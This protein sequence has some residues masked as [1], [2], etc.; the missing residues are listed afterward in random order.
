MSSHNRRLNE[1]EAELDQNRQRMGGTLDALQKRLSTDDLFERVFG[2]L[3]TSGA[4][5][6]TH[7][8]SQSIRRNPVPLA[9][10]GIGLAW[11]AVAGS[12]RASRAVSE[13][14][15]SVNTERLGQAWSSAG[16]RTRSAADRVGE[17]AH[18][19]RDGMR[20]FSD[21]VRDRSARVGAASRRSAR[22]GADGITYMWR[23][24]PIMTAAIGLLLG[25]AVAAAIPRN[26]REDE[27]M[28][29][30]RD[31]LFDSARSAGEQG[32]DK[33]QSVAGSAAG[34]AQEAARDEARAQ[35]WSG[36]DDSADQKPEQAGATDVSDTWAYPRAE[37]TGPHEPI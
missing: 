15:P 28:G 30:A 9:T 32:L 27:L 25:A 22:A 31:D 34:A 33:A 8:L 36:S 12:D 2:Y 13:R 19:G 4:G 7:N 5:E 24:Q 10:V 17:A 35:G 26:V 23:E 11:L 18:S 20:D 6:F 29:D 37:R 16:E 3:D 14:T 1:L 21:G